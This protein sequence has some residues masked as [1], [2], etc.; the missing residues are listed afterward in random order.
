[1]T[2]RGRLIVI[3]LSL[4]VI[5]G[6]RAIPAQELKAPPPSSVMI[7][8]MTWVELR[9]LMR[10]GKTTIIVPTGGVEQNGPH[11]VLGKHDYIVRYTA[12]AIARKLGNAVVAPVI[13]YV[14]EGQIDPPEGHMQ[15]PGSISLPDDVYAGLLDAT[16]RSFAAE[17]FKAIVFLGDSGGNQAAQ[18]D[19]AKRLDA[20]FKTRGIRVL[21]A[22]AY[23]AAGGG[24]E[25]L[26]SQGYSAAEV[27]GH[28]SIRDTSELLAIHPEGVRTDRIATNG[29]LFSEPTGV[30]GDPSRAS[31]E[32]GRKLLAM[33]IDAAVQQISQ[34][35][36]NSQ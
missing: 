33:K 10:A 32:I 14:P 34:A 8:E 19:V 13:A 22:D 4:V 30:Q 1:M 15:F 2:R 9:T 27:D 11:M 5:V 24:P 26:K 20:A 23:Y 12:E 21:Q 28:A 18:A 3:T 6:L 29:G 7:E 16:A 36:G 25:W 31:A 17:G 35:L